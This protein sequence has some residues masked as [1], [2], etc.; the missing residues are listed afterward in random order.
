MALKD[1]VRLLPRP[2]PENKPEFSIGPYAEI[3]V[4]YGV[5]TEE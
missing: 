4:P 1:P 3:E 2:E 5:E